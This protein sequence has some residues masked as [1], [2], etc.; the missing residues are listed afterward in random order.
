MAQPAD[1]FKR[2]N[3]LNSLLIV[4]AACLAMYKPFELFLFSFLCLGPLHYLTELSWLE[5]KQFYSSD[6]K[7]AWLLVPISLA[8]M[9]PETIKQTHLFPV[10]STLLIAAVVYAVCITTT[11][12]LFKSIGLTCM[13]SVAAYFS[14]LAANPM[15]M[16]VFVLLLP[17]LIH[18]WL[19]TGLFMLTGI[20]KKAD[21]S[22]Y[23]SLFIFI[24]ASLTTLVIGPLNTAYM[25]AEFVA[26]HYKLNSLN[27]VL[28]NWLNLGNILSNEQVFLDKAAYGIMCF[29]AFSY[30]YHYLNWF[31]KTE[32]IGWHQ[33][34]VT[35][36]MIIGSIWLL[37]LGWYFLFPISGFWVISLLSMLHVLME[38]PLNIQTIKGMMKA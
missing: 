15:V 6:K 21:L 17:T 1:L 35:R 8:I 25:P 38:L 28:S 30:T 4:I 32:I 22:G 24:L 19:F 34:S 10:I 18:V 33:I 20:R 13:I 5:K 16:I 3:H 29:I 12:S 11:S 9:I 14:G 36:L 7:A 23:L 27:K 31:S 26:N 37:L 2:I